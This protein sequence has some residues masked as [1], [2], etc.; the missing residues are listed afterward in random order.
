L[1]KA[2]VLVCYSSAVRMVKMAWHTLLEDTSI[3]MAEMVIAG[4]DG[5]SLV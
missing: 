5:Q 2:E 4:E 1:A 3:Q